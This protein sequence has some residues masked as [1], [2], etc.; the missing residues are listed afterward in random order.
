M[1]AAN[2]NYRALVMLE[3]TGDADPVRAT[4]DA[5]NWLVLSD[6]HGNNVIVLSPEQVEQ[7][8]A[9]AAAYPI[10]KRCREVE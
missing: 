1:I 8:A 6:Q 5:E 4:L 3:A 7:L 10:A 2:N 9:L